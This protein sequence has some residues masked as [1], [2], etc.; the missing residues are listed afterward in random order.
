LSFSS[1]SWIFLSLDSTDMAKRLAIPEPAVFFGKRRFPPL[2]RGHGRQWRFCGKCA[3]LQAAVG[4]ELTFRGL[5]G[6]GV[7]V[8]GT[9]NPGL[10]GRKGRLAAGFSRCLVRGACAARGLVG[11]II[12][13]SEYLAGKGAALAGR[14]ALFLAESLRAGGRNIFVEQKF[15]IICV[16]LDG[17]RAKVYN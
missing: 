4:A 9:G 3:G 10:E 13:I 16:S 1:T 14:R 17:L 7:P 2:R 6:E 11:R 8:R 5:G 15:G 12:G